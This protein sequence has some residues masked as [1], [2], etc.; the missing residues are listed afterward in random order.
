MARVFLEG[1]RWFD[2]DAAEQKWEG[3]EETGE[4]L[5]LSRKGCYVEGRVSTDADDEYTN[6]RECTVDGAVGFFVAHDI[7]L[8]DIPE[9]LRADIDDLE[10]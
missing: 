5:W 10:V 4:V 3:K 6:C 7:P 9:D 8:D 1:G 2:P